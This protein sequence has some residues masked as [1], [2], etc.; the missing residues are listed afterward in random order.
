MTDEDFRKIVGKNLRREREKNGLAIR[1]VAD[2]LKISYQ[3][4]LN[5]EQAIAMPRIFTLYKLAELYDVS[6]DYLVEGGDD[7]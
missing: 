6:I 4:Y 7:D 3:A 1:D 5:Y 2:L